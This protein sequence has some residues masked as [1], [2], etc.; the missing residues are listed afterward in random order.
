ME[1]AG[2]CPCAARDRRPPLPEE[3][4]GALDRMVIG[5]V[6]EAALQVRRAQGSGAVVSTSSMGG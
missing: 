2:R 1:A 5:V 3:C 4:R 6:A